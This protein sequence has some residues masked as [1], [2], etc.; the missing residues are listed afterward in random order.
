MQEEGDG[1]TESTTALHV[2]SVVEYLLQGIQ[3]DEETRLAN[4]EIF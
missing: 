4:P 1:L 3:T 2:S